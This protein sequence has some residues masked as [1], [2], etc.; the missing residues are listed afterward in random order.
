M[1]VEEVRLSERLSE[2]YMRY[3]R[4]CTRGAALNGAGWHVGG[5]AEGAAA[6]A[7]A[8]GASGW[9]GRSMKWIDRPPL[10]VRG[11]SGGLD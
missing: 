5:W 10:S 8:E 6:G 3:A 1:D 2:R 11:P 7:A 4:V 9:V